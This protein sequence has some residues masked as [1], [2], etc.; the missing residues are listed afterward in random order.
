MP[1]TIPTA[2]GLSGLRVQGLLDALDSRLPIS[3]E[4]LLHQVFNILVAGNGHT[5]LLPCLAGVKII[6]AIYPFALDGM[7]DRLL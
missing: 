6:I 5:A 7:F 4:S 2:C 1:T 3:M